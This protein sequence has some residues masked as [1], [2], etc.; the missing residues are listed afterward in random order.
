MVA[1]CVGSNINPHAN[2]SK[3]EV[4]LAKQFKIFAVSKMVVTKPVGFAQQADFI[5]GA[6]LIETELSITKLRE[7]LCEI[8]NIC[9]R[10]RTENKNGPRTLD[11]DVVVFN[12]KI[13]DDDFYKYD[14]VK[15]RILAIMPG[16]SY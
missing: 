4:H 2:I 11:L 16:L 1:I 8:E 15:D 5:N 13:I 7:A 10:V 12:A 14:F 6:F 9:G 3:G